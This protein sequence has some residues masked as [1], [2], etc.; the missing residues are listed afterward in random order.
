MA[1]RAIQHSQCACGLS[2]R[3]DRATY[4]LLLLK[5][6]EIDDD[7]ALLRVVEAVSNVDPKMTPRHK[8]CCSEDSV[9]QSLA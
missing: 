2:L 1:P 3:L 5:S 7:V 8:R 9:D 6:V 4:L